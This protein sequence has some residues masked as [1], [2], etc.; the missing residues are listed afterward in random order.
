MIDHKQ[1]LAQAGIVVLA[2]CVGFGAGNFNQARLLNRSTQ[3]NYS[4]SSTQTTGQV[5]TAAT[6]DDQAK[7]SQEEKT[8]QPSPV[9]EQ[10][11]VKS[12]ATAECLIKGNIS[13]SKQKI[14]HIKGGMFYERVKEE[15]CF[16][17]EEE[18]VKAGFRKSEK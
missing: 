6:Q 15:M 17:T 7:K 5:N 14:Y 2:F 13:S 11:Q 18:A 10:A 12:A 1:Q 16:S 9:A 4:K 3:A 8:T